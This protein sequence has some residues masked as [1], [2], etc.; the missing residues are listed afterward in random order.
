MDS[1]D[2]RE[3]HRRGCLSSEINVVRL[4]TAIPEKLAHLTI[5]YGDHLVFDAITYFA[6]YEY[7]LRDEVSD[8]KIKELLTT[9]ALTSLQE[10]AD[11]GIVIE[12]QRPNAEAGSIESIGSLVTVLLLRF[13]YL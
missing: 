1:R 10:L 6:L 4:V 11:Y 5:R 13:Q 9:H 2:L 8:A 12:L 7:H 3:L